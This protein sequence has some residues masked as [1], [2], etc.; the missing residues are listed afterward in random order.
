MK[1]QKKKYER[2]LK[3][4]DKERIE[5]EKNLLKDFGLRRKG[6]IW[7]SEALL[8]KYRRL[9]RNLAARK[10]K[11]KEKILIEKLT[12]MGLLEK[13]AGLDDVLSLTIENILE[14]RLQ[15]IVFRKGLANT[16]KQAR[17][18]IVHG[19]ITLNQ[20]KISYPSYLV[21]REEENK[22]QVIK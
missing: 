1:R 3:P 18:L 15:T 17:Q 11:E 9:A 21:E 22:I 8:R 12:K 19:K 16:S 13:N 2:P 14:R 4:W 10:D 6:E 20:R 5:K 7:K